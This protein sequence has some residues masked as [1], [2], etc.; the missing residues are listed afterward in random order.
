MANA[1]YIKRFSR[2]CFTLVPTLIVV[3]LVGSLRSAHAQGSYLP[4]HRYSFAN[5]VGAGP[6]GSVVTDSVGTADGAVKGAGAAFTGTR[7][8]I[9]GGSS[10]TAAY[11]DLPN[12]LF[13]DNST[14]RGGS[15]Q[16]TVETFVK[17]T[18]GRT[19]S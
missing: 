9:P 11:I 19:W 4:I 10:A 7:V 6:D 15:G 12:G 1:M 8:T 17:V 14:N 3:A 2:V 16:V 18:G 5:P 13:S